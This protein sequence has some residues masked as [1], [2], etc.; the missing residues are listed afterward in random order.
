MTWGYFISWLKE[1]IYDLGL[2]YFMTE[3]GLL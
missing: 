1:T 2:L 3:R